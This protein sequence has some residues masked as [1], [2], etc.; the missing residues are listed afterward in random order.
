MQRVVRVYILVTL[1]FKSRNMMKNI[2]KYNLKNIL[3]N[4]SIDFIK[5]K[6]SQTHVI[7]F[8]NRIIY[9]GRGKGNIFQER[10]ST[11]CGD[12]DWGID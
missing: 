9:G 4:N 11:N 1:A 10:V 5:S 8:Y 3:Y 2:I 6:L 12:Q 7:F